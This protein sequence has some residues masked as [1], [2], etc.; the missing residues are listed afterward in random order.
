MGGHGD[1]VVGRVDVHM[2]VAVVLDVI[3]KALDT[4]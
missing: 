2:A 1:E 3:L 4:R